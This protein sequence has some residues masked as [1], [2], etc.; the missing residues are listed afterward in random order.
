ML[1]DDSTSAWS[2][3]VPTTS[4][5]GSY[6][7]AI[8]LITLLLVLFSSYSS[9]AFH[10][11][12]VRIRRV[13]A[14]TAHKIK[15]ETISNSA[16]AS[17]HEAH[18]NG[19]EP[20]KSRVHFCF[21]V[22]GYR[23]LAVD[24][25]YLHST[26]NNAASK[27]LNECEDGSSSEIDTIIITHTIKCNEYRTNDGVINGGDRVALEVLKIVEAEIEVYDS[28]YTDFTL[29]FIG[30][31]LGGIYCRH[32]IY[33]LADKFGLEDEGIIQLCMKG[34]YTLR[35]NSYC[36]M[37]SPHL[38][39]SGHTYVSLPRVL[40]NLIGRG[41]GQTGYDLFQIN[42][43]LKTMATSEEYLRVLRSFE[44]RVAYANVFQTDFPV[45]T[46]TAAF[47]SNKSTYP[48]QKLH[49]K[50]NI[51][52]FYTKNLDAS[53]NLV[54]SDNDVG[55]MTDMSVSLDSLGW[56]KVFVDMRDAMFLRFRSKTTIGDTF[57]GAGNDTDMFESRQIQLI[58]NKPNELPSAIPLGHNAIVAM[59][60]NSF[61]S[62]LNAGGRPIMDDFVKDFMEVI[63]SFKTRHASTKYS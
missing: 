1:I 47:L 5:F 58:L 19:S 22:H 24:L 57:T 53:S 13:P 35:F 54:I 14:L 33:R 6:M 49:S 26:L 30:I 45:P 29:S 20:K 11:I 41:M 2:E 21:L 50:S 28:D 32:A 44:H 61:H 23:G 42:D 48:H 9:Q 10:P 62:V 63:F 51:V 38:G 46:D 55:S 56:K 40:E 59:S 52:T 27:L 39:V 8:V 12:S 25:S 7:F 4:V 15:K 18:N 36:S 60:R 34:K 37:A 17:S 31:S 3:E 16:N 43:L